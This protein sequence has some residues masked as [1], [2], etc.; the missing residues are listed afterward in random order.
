MDSNDLMRARRKMQ[1][2]LCDSYHWVSKCMLYIWLNQK[3]QKIVNLFVCNCSADGDGNRAFLVQAH[4]YRLKSSHTPSVQRKF[5]LKLS[6][7]ALL[8]SSQMS[9]DQDNWVILD[10]YKTMARKKCLQS[11]TVC[12]PTRGSVNISPKLSWVLC[13]LNG[14]WKQSRQQTYTV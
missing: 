14:G 5:H 7:T 9:H 2:M 6:T 4:Y 10:W 13:G 8:A 12:G 1:Y 3:R 11:S